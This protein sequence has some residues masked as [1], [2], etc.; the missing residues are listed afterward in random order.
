MAAGMINPLVFR[1]M[2]KSWR[3][4]ELT[5]FLYAFYSEVEDLTNSSFFHPITIRRMFSSEQEREL[6]LKKQ[7]L[8]GFAKY[9]T[10]ITPDDTSYARAIN[11]FGSGR[12]KKSAYVD[13]SIFLDAIKTWIH[14]NGT[15][16]KTDFKYNDLDGSTYQGVHYDHIIFCEG[17]LGKANPWFGQLPLS[18]TKGETLTFRAMN[19]PE[20][21]SLNRKCF[22]LP[23]G[24]QTFKVGSTYVWN[25]S[26]VNI[27]PEGR[28]HILD[29]LSYLIDA[30]VQVIDQ[31]AG[32][33]PT[34]SDRR[35]LIGTHETRKNY[36]I[37]N[38]LGTKGYMLAPL[39][40]ME[41][42]DYLLNDTPLDAEVNINRHY[43]Q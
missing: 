16:L 13:T 8:P 32:V 19:V 22:V 4:D 36:H 10:T 23:L 34:T 2:T 1:R 42:V 41:F 25:T 40:S 17:Y 20:D 3:V 21:E 26:D 28:Q 18:Q 12:V 27:T 35:P 39:L 38:G 29:N 30:E 6:W 33:R 43:K 11:N 24:K 14:A 37:F 5:P 9:M 15:I 7:E 31:A